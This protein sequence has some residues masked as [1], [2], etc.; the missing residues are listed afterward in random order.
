MPISTVFEILSWNLDG[1]L[2]I[3]SHWWWPSFKV[4]LWFSRSQQT[5]AYRTK[6]I[7]PWQFKLHKYNHWAKPFHLDIGPRS[8]YDSQGHNKLLPI[9]Q[10][11]FDLESSNLAQIFLA[12]SPFTMTLTQGHLFDFKVTTDFCR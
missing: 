1:R 11:P 7:W 10:R 3:G 9:E 2:L 6:T 12:S 4:T 5:F 8:N